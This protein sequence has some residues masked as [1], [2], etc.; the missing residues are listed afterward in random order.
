MD[1]VKV[2]LSLKEGADFETVLESAKKTGF[3][4]LTSLPAIKIAMGWAEPASIVALRAIP[5]VQGAELE[6]AKHILS[7]AD[8]SPTQTAMLN[9]EAVQRITRG[10]RS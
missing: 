9:E 1:P 6:G 5:G 2:I 7:G 3:T 4:L 10:W 8:V